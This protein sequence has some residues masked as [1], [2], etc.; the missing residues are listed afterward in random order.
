VSRTAILSTLLLTLAV[1]GA[2][3]GCD[4][5]NTPTNSQPK[6]I[7]NN[8]DPLFMALN[9]ALS[10]TDSRSENL[11]LTIPFY[12]LDS[13]FQHPDYPTEMATA[14]PSRLSPLALQA[15]SAL[16]EYHTRSEYWYFAAYRIVGESN[17]LVLDYVDSVQLL[18]GYEPVQWPDSALLTSMKSG[19]RYSFTEADTNLIS[20][21]QDMVFGGNPYDQEPDTLNAQCQIETSFFDT[22]PPSQYIYKVNVASIYDDLVVIL[23]P[24]WTS[25]PI[26]GLATHTGWLDIDY[27]VDRTHVVSNERWRVSERYLGASIDVSAENSTTRWRDTVQCLS[28]P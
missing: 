27:T 7:G 24:I 4:D 17:P 22:Q 15:D 2:Q 3:L 25:C 9:D 12:V 23:Q 21:R 14:R 13:V 20:S 5:D 28:F 11:A 18:H 8:D 1:V 26:D 6:A 10:Q 19:L 16:L